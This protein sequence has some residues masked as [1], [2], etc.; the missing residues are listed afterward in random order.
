M[1][2]PRTSISA[3]VLSPVEVITPAHLPLSGGPPRLPAAGSEAALAPDAPD[4]FSTAI[5]SLDEVE[6][7]YIQHVVASCKGNRSEAA[8]VLG[9][10]RNTLHRKLSESG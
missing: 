6:R 5:R 9:I 8:R 3:V 1:R 10:G 2:L 4:R 7:A